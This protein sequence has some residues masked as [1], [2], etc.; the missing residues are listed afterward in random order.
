MALPI[1]LSPFGAGALVVAVLLSLH[2]FRISKAPSLESFPGAGFAL[3]V[4]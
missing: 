2:L 4:C 3:F 1:L